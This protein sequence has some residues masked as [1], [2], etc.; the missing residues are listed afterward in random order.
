MREPCTFRLERVSCG[1]LGCSRCEG[2]KPAHGP[3]WYAYWETGGRRRP[4]MHKRY[5]GRAS[6]TESPEELRA[7]FE[8][9]QQRCAEAA[10]RKRR[11]DTRS[12]TGSSTSGDRSEPGGDARTGGSASGS[13]NAGTSGGTGNTSGTGSTG[14][15]DRSR[16]DRSDRTK[17]DPFSRRRPPPIE[18]DFATINAKRGAT[19]EEARQAYREAAQRAHPDRG[20]DVETMQRI[21]IAWDRIKQS[22][23]R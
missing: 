23:G 21:N 22:F 20:G 8:L 4:R 2:T 1:K 3:Y 5:I 15:D 19:F 17:N 16:Y 14:R 11:R 7:I 10:E 12:D 18:E 6:A 9:R 13:A